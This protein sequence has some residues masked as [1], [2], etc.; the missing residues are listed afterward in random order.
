MDIG[1][2]VF[3]GCDIWK[4]KLFFLAIRS[5]LLVILNGS[6]VLFISLYKNVL[7]G[8]WLIVDKILIIVLLVV[9]IDIWLGLRRI[10]VVW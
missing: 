2:K 6:W 4:F 1:S 5:V 10:L 8:F 3:L 9:V 7:L